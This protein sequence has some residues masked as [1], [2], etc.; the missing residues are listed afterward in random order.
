MA[1]GSLVDLSTLLS[2]EVEIFQ[3][4]LEAGRVC[5]IYRRSGEP[6]NFIC[7][8]VTI[9]VFGCKTYQHH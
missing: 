8:W 4:V 6:Q 9:E 5:D 7:F 2:K 1:V 3:A